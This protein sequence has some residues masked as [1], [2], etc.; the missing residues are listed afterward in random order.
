MIIH[1]SENIKS[2]HLFIKKPLKYSD[3]FTFIPL[4][5]RRKYSNLSAIISAICKIPIF[6]IKII[7]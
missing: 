5:L 7:F 3:K 6:P 2:Y 1:H 4:R